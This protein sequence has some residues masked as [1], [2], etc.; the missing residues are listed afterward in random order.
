MNRTIALSAAALFLVSSFGLKAQGTGGIASGTTLDKIVAVVGDEIVMYSD[1]LAQLYFLKQQNPKLNID[2]PELKSRILES[3]IND[4]LVV[5]KASEDTVKVEDEEVEQM[6]NYQVQNFIR[7]Y[8]SE[9]RVEEVFG[10]PIAQLKRDYK[11]DIRK[12]LMAQRLTQQRFGDVKVSRRDVEEFFQEYK[13]SIPTIPAE[14]E[15]A[16]IVVF[17]RPDSS[18]KEATFALASRLRDSIVAGADFAALAKNWSKDPGSAASGGELGWVK[19]GNFVAEYEKAVS[20]LQIGQISRPVESP[21]GVHIIQL[22]DRRDDETKTRH[23]LLRIEQTGSEV[24]LVKG[25][26]DSIKTEVAKGAKFADLARK[27][28][29]DQETKGFG[30]SL[31]KVDPNTFPEN[32]RSVITAL[33]DGDVSAPMAYSNNPTKSGFHIIQRVKTHEQ[34]KPTLDSD[35]KKIEQLAI[36]W[37]KNKLYEEWIEELRRTM[38]WDVLE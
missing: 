21:F 10:L 29:E 32:L 22:L 30:G 24:D 11:D 7:Q 36:M 27:F 35:Y 25:L 31:G 3:M 14:V 28:S 33:K 18:A 34:H 38:H 13:D 37:K 23:I 20:V 26:L 4:K 5:S 6:L 16:H 9:K 2:D 8:G 19:K 1:L 15:L 17:V 12:R